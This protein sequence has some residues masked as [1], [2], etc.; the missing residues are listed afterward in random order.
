M[1]SDSGDAEHGYRTQNGGPPHYAG[2]HRSSL[3]PGP[4]R[5]WGGTR[6]QGQLPL[7]GTLAAH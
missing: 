4:Q 7:S 3:P 1:M 6:R 5:S 2:T